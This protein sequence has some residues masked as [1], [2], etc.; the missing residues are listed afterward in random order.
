MRGIKA[1]TALVQVIWLLMPDIVRPRHRRPPWGPLLRALCVWVRRLLLGLEELHP[2]LSNDFTS[3]LLYILEAQTVDF[4]TG[5]VVSDGD[6]SGGKGMDGRDGRDD[7]AAR[8]SNISADALAI[9]WAPGRVGGVV[10]I[11]VAVGGGR[12]TLPNRCVDL[13][14]AA[15]IV[16]GLALH[17]RPLCT[18]F[19]IEHIVIWR[20]E[21]VVTVVFE[22]LGRTQWLAAG[23]HEELILKFRRE[24]EIG[25]R[26]QVVGKEGRDLA[27]WA[28][29]GEGKGGGFDTAVFV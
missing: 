25:V 14:A 18:E 5:S 3:I 26:L 27:V 23:S 2:R 11:V 1:H 4:V 10:V 17:L 9:P 20:D 19:A 24:E 22:W 7:A 6:R 15:G 28:D 21:L 16:P 8:A 12:E 29:Y 13:A